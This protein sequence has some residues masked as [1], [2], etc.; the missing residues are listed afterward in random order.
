MIDLLVL[1]ILGAAGYALYRRSRTASAERAGMLQP[2]ET[3]LAEPIHG[4]DPTGFGSL[5]GRFLDMPVEVRVIPEALAFRRLPQ[6]WVSV[7]VHH[8]TGVRGTID[9][10]R[11]VVGVEFY[12]PADNLP[13]RYDVPEGW[14][15]ET[16]VRGSP[17]AEPLLVR[18][19]G[20]IASILT[21]PRVKEVLLTPRGIRIVSQLCQG[22]RGAYLLLRENRFPVT[23]IGPEQLRPLLAQATGLVWSLTGEGTAHGSEQTPARAAA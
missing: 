8:A 19:S 14:P 11:R 4:R 12:A 15:G 10:L 22:D 5:A 16:L 1:P 17:G 2:C 6:L 9:V 3:L 13:A 7:S 23:Q 21:E 18:A 20:A